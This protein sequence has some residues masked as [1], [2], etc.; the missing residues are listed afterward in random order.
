M[1]LSILILIGIMAIIAI[2][3]VFIGIDWSRIFGSET[4]EKDVSFGEQGL[5]G[6]EVAELFK[7]VAET[8]RET[9]GSK[10]LTSIIYPRDFYSICSKGFENNPK[11]WTSWQPAERFRTHLTEN[12]TCRF[13][14]S[15]VIQLE[16][17]F[18]V[19]CFVH[20]TD[21][22]LF[23]EDLTYDKVILT[24]GL[25]INKAPWNKKRLQRQKEFIE[26]VASTTNDLISM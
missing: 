7:K 14:T 23:H 8:L 15:W 10:H 12:Y 26:K 16:S 3:L 6:K 18:S 1:D 13:R 11:Q 5:T 22:T 19:M 20:N 9:K 24:C 25:R 2:C 4:V 17:N 21:K